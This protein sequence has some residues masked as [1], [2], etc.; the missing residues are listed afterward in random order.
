MKRILPVIIVLASVALLIAG[1]NIESSDNKESTTATT[2]VTTTVQGNSKLVTLVQETTAMAAKKKTVYYS[3]NIGASFSIPLKWENKYAV[4]DS[5]AE[6]GSKYLSFFDKIN[7][8]N[9]GK[10]LVFTYNLFITDDYKK[11]TG[12]TEYGTVTTAD[13]MTYYIVCTLPDKLQYDKKSKGL[14]KSYEELNQEKYIDYICNGVKFDSVLTLDKTGCSTEP[15]STAPAS[16]AT[17]EDSQSA[18]AKPRSN[19]S[20]TGINGLVFSDIS[21]RRLTESEIK[22]LS[23]DKIQQA[24]ND[25]CAING[26]NFNTKSIKE[27]YQQFSWYKPSGN[28]SES[29]FNSIEKYNYDLLQRYR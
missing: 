18:A 12:Y 17:G 2:E 28:Y 11:G 16:T 29:N 10:G 5:V 26:Y 3:Q 4:E 14:K 7:H 22:S 13:N 24:I 19:N 9:N 6:D 20:N 27:H 8:S 25:I 23:S 15:S 21:T 1:C